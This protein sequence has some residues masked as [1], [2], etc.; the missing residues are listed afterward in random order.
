MPA[1]RPDPAH[2]VPHLDAIAP[3]RALHR[4]IVHGEYDATSLDEW[5]DGGA[6]LHAR[7]LFAE[8]E[9]PAREIVFRPGEQESNLQ[10]KYILAI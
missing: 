1:P 2:A 8:H 4:P 9:F 7:P 10:R 3:P 6:R 5:H